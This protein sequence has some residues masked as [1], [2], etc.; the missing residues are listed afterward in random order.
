MRTLVIEDEPQIGAYL[1]RLLGQLHGIVD[2]VASVSD[3]QQAPS[4]FQDD[5]AI[6][7]RMLPDGDALDIVTALTQLPERPAI[8][9]LTAKDTK[10]DVIDGLNCGAGD[11]LGKPF[12]PQE[13]IARGRGGLP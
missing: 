3:A 2:I 10:E 11:Y 5:L 7:D 4:N 6:I 12:A 9:M 1:G 13:F 8:I